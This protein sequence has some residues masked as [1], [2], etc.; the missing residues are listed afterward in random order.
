MKLSKIRTIVAAA[1][2][3]V[4]AV[5]LIAGINMGTLSGFG[6]DSFSAL[7]P[8]GAITTMLA[9]KTLV[10]RAV[11]S[12]IIMALLVFLFG[13]ILLGVPSMIIGLIAFIEF[14]IYLTK[15]DED[16]EQTY[17]VGRKPWF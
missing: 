4:L 16:F 6:F 9:T 15:T 12:I 17:V 8:L 14:I 1:V 11:F 5:G 7:C 10:P 13:F 3:C 2:F